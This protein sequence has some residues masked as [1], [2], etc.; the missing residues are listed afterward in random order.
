MSLQIASR[1]DDPE[2]SKANTLQ[3]NGYQNPRMTATTV[4]SKGSVP[5]SRGMD[6]ALDRCTTPR[7]R[8]PATF[9][10]KA[11]SQSR[12]RAQPDRGLRAR[13]RNPVHPAR[14]VERFR[15]LRRAALPR[16][17]AAPKT[18]R[19]TKCRFLLPE[20]T[21][22]RRAPTHR[23]RISGKPLRSIRDGR[24]TRAAGT[25]GAGQRS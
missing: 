10:R 21:A 3:L 22:D 12:H 20:K 6:V 19:K 15:S 7:R 17:R 1:T 2:A 18:A 9:M 23:S 24:T 16:N 5:V 14:S 11:Q 25:R 8:F 4:K 13:R